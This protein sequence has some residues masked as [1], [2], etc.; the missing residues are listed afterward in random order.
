MDMGPG[1]DL[2]SL[3][4]YLGVWIT[5]MAAMMLPSALPMVLLFQQIA[6][7]R[8]RAGSGVV[9][10]SV[11]VAS[12]LGVWTLYGVG[13]YGLYRLISELE[14][15]V[16]GW[17]RAGSYFAGAAIVLA[18]VY[19][20]TPLKTVCLRH[21]RSPMHYVLAGWRSGWLGAIR[22]GAEHGSFCVGCCWGLML[23]LFALGAMSLFWMALVATLIFL[24]KV[25]PLGERL[26][27]LFAAGLVA[28]GICVA[29][30]PE[31][32]PGLHYPRPGT[33]SPMQME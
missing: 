28:L 13:A 25:L 2:G 7:R 29:V 26:P 15:D 30:L 24:Q 8:A 31:S 1:T 22:M 4:W 14:L 5:M 20:L 19:E 17:G 6:A 10:T 12:Y 32:V 11:F 16:L 27:R 33:S 23:I 3:G 18:G 21:C 9:P